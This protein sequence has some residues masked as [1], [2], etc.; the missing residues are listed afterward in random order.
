M[1]RATVLAL[2]DSF[3]A[4]QSEDTEASVLYDEVIRELGFYEVLTTR[5]DQFLPI[6]A[7]GIYQLSPDTMRVLEVAWNQRRVDRSSEFSIRSAFGAN[8]R[9]LRGQPV[10]V[11]VWEESANTIRFIPQPNSGGTVTLIKTETRE[12]LPYWLELPVALMVLHRE[13]IRESNHQDV[14]FAK[15]AFELGKLFMGLVK[16]DIIIPQSAVQQ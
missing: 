7:N 5:E 12:D 13:F 10:A 16:V 15:L 9:S 3:S 4:D 14:D 8:W 1:T 11:T 6:S 2:I